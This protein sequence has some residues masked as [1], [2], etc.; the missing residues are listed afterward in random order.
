MLKWKQWL[1]LLLVALGSLL[2]WVAVTGKLFA[3]LGAGDSKTGARGLPA[4]PRPLMAGICRLRRRSSA[5]KSTSMPPS[6]S[7][8]GLPG[9][10]LP[11]VLPTSC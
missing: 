11:G 8:G 9:L 6:L 4:A 7:P 1:G 2:T 3:L 5:G 10:S